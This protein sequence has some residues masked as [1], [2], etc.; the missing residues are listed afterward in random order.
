MAN[1]I[2]QR[3]HQYWS[4]EG[5]VWTQWYTVSIPPKQLEKYEMKSGRKPLFCEYRYVEAGHNE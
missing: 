1:K 3:R 2:L 5:V 4:P